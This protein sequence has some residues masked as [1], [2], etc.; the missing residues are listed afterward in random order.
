MTGEIEKTSKAT[1]L[2]EKEIQMNIGAREY[3]NWKL[4]R[5]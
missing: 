1:S 4:R 2:L 3:F 5:R